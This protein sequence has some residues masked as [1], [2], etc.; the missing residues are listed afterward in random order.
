[1]PEPP[2]A[3]Q[4]RRWRVARGARLEY[5]SSGPLRVT[6]ACV[7]HHPISL[8][9]A[10]ALSLV[11]FA[12]WARALEPTLVAPGVYALIGDSLERSSDNPVEIGN[13]GFIV[14]GDGVLVI[15]TG[16]SHRHGRAMIEAIR[17]VTD[18][19]ITLVIITH[20]AQAFL[21]GGAAFA[22]LQVPLLTHARSA[23]LMQ[24]RCERCLQDLQ[25]TLGPEA[26]AGTRLVIPERTVEASTAL[27]LGDRHLE[28]LY[29][30]WASTPGDLS[31]YDPAT[32]TL[33]AGGLITNRRIPEVRDAK[34]EGWLRALDGLSQL[35]AK[36]IVPGYGPVGG[37][38][39]VDQTARY[40]RALEN[41][42]QRLYQGGASLQEALDNSA[43]PDFAGWTQY[44]QLHRRNVQHRYL[45]LELEELG[46]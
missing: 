16:I 10:A 26:M 41:Q 40:L 18:R 21:F 20:A 11:F 30:G 43:L 42:V 46:G 27:A 37:S 7:L 2:R 29:S 28:L 32:G 17:H 4:R 22:E 5:R 44:P 12:S 19:P 35:H 15:D 24:Q 38:E 36:R 6:R 8:P 31:V 9:L 45:E 14:G 3:R 34:L 25:R 33:F 1:M 39:L 23:Q 13:S